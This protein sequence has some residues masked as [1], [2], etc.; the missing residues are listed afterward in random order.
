MLV[1]WHRLGS[2]NVIFSPRLLA[3]DKEIVVMQSLAAAE[4]AEAAAAIHHSR[5]RVASPLERRSRVDDGENI[6]S[7]VQF[8]RVLTSALFPKRNNAF[9]RTGAFAIEGSER[10]GLEESFHC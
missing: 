6:E 4:Y 2:P 7:F 1:R 8:V 10:F 5:E 3:S 9:E